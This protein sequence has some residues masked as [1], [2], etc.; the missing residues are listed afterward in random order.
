VSLATRRRRAVACRRRPGARSPSVATRKQRAPPRIFR[1]ARVGERVHA[2]RGYLR[3]ASPFWS[4][5]ETETCPCVPEASGSERI[6]AGAGRLG[7]V[8]LLPRPPRAPGIGM[9]ERT[10]WRN[11]FALHTHIMR[12]MRSSRCGVS[13]DHMRCHADRTGRSL[14]GVDP[15]HKRNELN[16][17]CSPLGA[18]RSGVR[19]PVRSGATR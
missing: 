9:G 3:R 16:G 1:P 18:I 8:R 10:F 7:R 5:P 14:H 2:R 6:V 4:V 12:E 17:A 13:T 15:S 11:G 19:L